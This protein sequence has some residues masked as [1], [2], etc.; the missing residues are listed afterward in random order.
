VHCVSSKIEAWIE[1]GVALIIGTAVG[2]T[3]APGVALSVGK[4][5]ALTLGI[6]VGLIVISAF[7]V[8]GGADAGRFAVAH[9]EIIHN[10]LIAS[11]ITSMRFIIFSPIITLRLY[12]RGNSF[13][14]TSRLDRGGLH[15][16][17]I[18]LVD[19]VDRKDG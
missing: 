7:D 15:L 14:C 18:I 13:T 11:I 17:N 12:L 16:V 3:A 2:L 4:G 9:P 1:A 19:R 5:V 6:G 10:M 8:G